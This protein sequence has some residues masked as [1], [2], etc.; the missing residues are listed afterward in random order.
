MGTWLYFRSSAEGDNETDIVVEH[1]PLL[2][3]Y[4][5][6][7]LLLGGCIILAS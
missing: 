3:F 1:L 7:F 5:I 6:L 2:I 4:L